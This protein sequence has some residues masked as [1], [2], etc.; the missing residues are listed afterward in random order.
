VIQTLAYLGP[1]GTFTEEAAIKYAPKGHYLPFPSIPAVAQAVEAGI[2]DEGV[3][4]IENSLE[5]A[6]NDTLDLLIHDS[7]LCI[8]GEIVLPIEHCLMVLSGIE[9]DELQ[10]ISSHPQALGQCRNFLESRFPK[11]RARATLSTAAAV[12]SLKDSP[13]PAGAI[14]PPRAAVLYGAKILARGIQDRPNN[15]TRFV[16]LAKTDH[17]PTGKDKTSLGFSFVGDDPGLL[18]SVLGEFAR[19]NINLAKIESRPTKEALGRYIFLVDLEGHREEH[20][21]KEVLEAV[22]DKVSML[23]VFGSYPCWSQSQPVS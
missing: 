11:I 2:T 20:K 10:A 19:R 18:Y 8:R 9:E 3:L 1:A 23:K 6:V 16:V 14:A 12:E 17:A 15:L 4:P 21:I 5:G 22:D 7:T 13:V